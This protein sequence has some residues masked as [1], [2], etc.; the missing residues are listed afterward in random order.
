MKSKNSLLVFTLAAASGLAFTYTVNAATVVWDRGAGTG[1]LNDAVN[2][3]GD[4][5]PPT[6]ETIQFDNTAAGAQ[7][8]TFNAAVGGTGGYLVDITAA[9]TGAVTITNVNVA[10]SQNFRVI[11]G[12]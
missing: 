8:L 6:G 5:L 9:Q 1:D 10:T 12:T 2:W 3:V 7:A 11:D 4:V